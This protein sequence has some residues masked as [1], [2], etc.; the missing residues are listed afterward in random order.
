MATSTEP[1]ATRSENDPLQALGAIQRLEVG[2]VR[3]E[4]RRLTVDYRVFQKGRTDS[5]ELIYKFEEDVFD[6]DEPESRNLA[7][8]LSVQVALNYGLFCD[9]IAFL[10][11]FDKRDRQFIQQM[12]RHT[13]REIFVKRF[14]EPN[15][16]IEGPARDLPPVKRDDYLRAR[17]LFDDNDPSQGDVPRSQARLNDWPVDPSVYAVLSSGGKDSLLT[18]G[19]LREM[20]HEVHPVFLNESGRHWFTALNAYRYFSTNIPHTARVWTNSDRLFNWMLRHL[21]FVRKDAS[22]IRSDEYP[23]RLWTVAVFLFGA[24][25]L[26]RKRGVGRLVIGDEF[27]TTRRLSYEGI[28]HYDGL[29]DQSRYFDNAMTRYFHRKGWGV[30]QFSLLRPLSELLIEKIL[31]ERYPE[32]QRHQTSCHATHKDGDRVRPCGRCEKC[33]RIVGMLTALDADPI[34]CSYRPDQIAHCLKNLRAKGIHQEKEGVEHLAFL[35][36]ENGVIQGNQIGSVRAWERPHIMKLRFDRERSP[37]EGIPVG[38][39][40]P[41]FR[42]YLSHADGSARP[43]GRSWIDFDLWTDPA[44]KRPYPFEMPGAI[45]SAGRGGKGEPAG[46]KVDF[47]LGELTWPEAQIRFQEVDVAL[48]PVGA[49]EQHGPHLPLDCDAFDA[50]YMAR[51]VA[52]ACK[53]PRPLVLPLIPYGVSYHHEDFSGTISISPETLSQMVY[54]IGMSAF[55]HGITKL[56]IIN[57]HGGNGPALHFAAQM[58]NRD[59]HIF[60]CVDTGETSD[61]DIYAMAETP[62]DVH[63]GEIETSTSLA[64]RPHLVQVAKARKFIPR[65]SSRYL[66]FTSKRSVGWYAHTSKISPTGVLGDPTKGSREKG[67]RMWQVMI[68][69]MVEFVEDLKRLSLDEIY[70]KRY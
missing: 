2:P 27:D 48:L 39:R 67:E 53:P 11:Q 52:E 59:A 26:L 69:H 10:G 17:L 9:E 57:G 23:I 43:R 34:G 16:F 49:I 66:D 37:V 6:P 50:E 33:R 58:I 61:P 28:T 36:N 45:S 55:R 29:Y 35:L 7:G 62:N 32:L 13:A 18:F 56:V 3:L 15:P 42:I 31:V 65:F 25:P 8:M 38:L 63:S 22:H 47:L 19:L 46:R 70:Q 14:L 51:K 5:A 40:E 54:N 64:T 68:Q 60:T 41:L 21:P 4:K 1:P 24:L 12:A 20:G 30:S 44:L